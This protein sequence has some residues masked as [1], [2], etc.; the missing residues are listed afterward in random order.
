MEEVHPL[1][2]L[3]T[4]NVNTR[5]RVRTPRIWVIRSQ[6]AY[7]RLAVVFV[8]GGIAGEG[9]CEFFG[10]KAETAV[11]NFD[12][13]IAVK[14]EGEAVEAKNAAHDAGVFSIIAQNAAG[15]A[16]IKADAANRL[17]GSA[18]NQ[19]NTANTLASNAITVVDQLQPRLTTLEKD[20]E[21]RQLNTGK[22]TDA[23]KGVPKS[24]L[25]VLYI[26]DDDEVANVMN[27]FLVLVSG[28]RGGPHWQVKETRPLEEADAIP[29]PGITP[30]GPGVSLARRAGAM[31]G[32]GVSAKYIGPLLPGGPCSACGLAKAFSE[33]LGITIGTT[34]DARIPENMVRVIIDKKPGRR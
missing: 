16:Q 4:H 21:W 27:Q 26:A 7:A 10:A 18:L 22:F 29:T 32:I 28:H 12:N 19:S 2:R 13:G 14:A 23:L 24:E 1:N 25:Q 6:T 17:S 15:D 31:N 34:S 9:F 20:K 30:V 5:T 3:H 11:R 8:I 33:S